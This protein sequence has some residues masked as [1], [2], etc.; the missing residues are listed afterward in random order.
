MFFACGE[1][2]LPEA[3]YAAFVLDLSL[4]IPRVS[5]IVIDTHPRRATSEARL[6]RCI[7]L[8]SV[9]EQTL[10]YFAVNDRKLPTCIG[11]REWSRAFFDS[12]SNTSDISTSF[13]PAASFL[14][15][16]ILTEIHY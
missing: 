1:G 13:P 16:K 4:G 2:S 10:L 11:V 12:P 6:R 7:P 5:V 15:S 9:H 3:Q 14:C 8:T